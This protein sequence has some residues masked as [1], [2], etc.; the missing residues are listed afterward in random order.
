M[1]TSK[2]EL[3]ELGLLQE[4]LPQH[5]PVETHEQTQLKKVG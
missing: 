1:F 3:L 2:V 5:S 4:T